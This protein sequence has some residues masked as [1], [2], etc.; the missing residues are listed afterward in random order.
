MVKFTNNSKR[1]SPT[2]AQGDDDIVQVIEESRANG[3]MNTYL[4]PSDI[5]NSQFTLVRNARIKADKVGRASGTT[6]LTPTKPDSSAVLLYTNFTR[7]NGS[8]IY[9]RFTKNKVYRKGTSSWT[10]ITSASPYSISDTDKISFTTINDRFFFTTGNK[11]IQ[12]IN[13]TL[14][15][16]AILGNSGKYKYITGFFNRL[17]GFNN[18]D[19]TTP[20]P[21]LVG[22]SGDLNFGE[23]NP[24]VDISAGSNPLVEAATDFADPGSGVFGFASVI[25]FLRER[26]LWAAT[27]QGVA[28]N[29]FNFQAVT[30]SFGCDCPSSAIAKR[31]GIVWYD[32]R[33]N[34][35]YDYSIGSSPKEIG[36]AIRN[37]LRN[38]VTNKAL[39]DGG[40]D[41]VLNEYH[42][43]IPN[44]S[45]A[46]TYI[47]V[48]NYETN[49]WR[50][51]T[52]NNAYGISSLDGVAGGLMI[53]DLVGTIDSLVG[54]IDSLTIAT[55]VQ[56]PTVYYP[57][58]NGDILQTSVVADNDNG[59]VMT[60]ILES[61]IFSTSNQDLSIMRFNIVFFPLRAG[62]FSLY[63]SKDA[64]INYSLYKDVTWDSSG[65]GIRRRITCVKHIRA[66]QYKWKL[67]CIQGDFDILDYSIEGVLV[68]FTKGYPN[69]RA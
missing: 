1:F 34:Q 14:N 37:E 60:M 35:V 61:K 29:P 67:V 59:E 39:I 28:S 2:Q 49:S 40:Y 46:V 22:W 20:N 30:A 50:E 36:D 62:T 23:W 43:C 68:D 12:E 16:Y 19:A 41:P 26:S 10:E 51:R 15:T 53:D 57:K 58:S 42:L 64:G 56:T 13:F 45:S 8:S 3:G 17:V 38:K 4:D 69:S 27:K 33:T 6:L 44:V 24:L 11:E 32:N 48:Y 31:N 52:I 25:L 55:T 18:Y 7:F 9:L 63:Y 54:T 5:P 47:Y 65:I 66:A 21:V